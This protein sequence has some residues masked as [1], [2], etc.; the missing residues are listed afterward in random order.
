MGTAHP[1][2]ILN[3]TG[4]ANIFP[5]FFTS[6]ILTPASAFLFFFFAFQGRLKTNLQQTGGD[7]RKA[8]RRNVLII[9]RQAGKYGEKVKRKRKLT[10]TLKICRT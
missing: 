5:V 8:P 3:E 2:L 7:K 9:D 4:N 6:S 10:S 1:F